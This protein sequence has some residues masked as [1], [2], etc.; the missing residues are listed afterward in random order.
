MKVELSEKEIALA[1]LFEKVTGVVPLEWVDL[2]KAIFFIVP[3]KTITRTIGKE[4]K[5]IRILENK[6]KKKV[7]VFGNSNNIKQF[8]QNLFNNV[9]IYH[10][11]V[12]DVMGRKE[13]FIVA[14]DRDKKKIL[15]KEGLRLKAA[16]KLMEKM[17]NATLHIRTKRAPT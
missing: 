1:N 4:G 15:G 12:M 14:E 3:Y 9:K 2:G 5:N 16:K 17:F 10:I 7:F 6:L 8:A 11:E 13:V